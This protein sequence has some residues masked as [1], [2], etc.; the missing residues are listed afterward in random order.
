CVRRTLAHAPI[1]AALLQACRT[2]VTTMPMDLIQQLDALETA[3]RQAGL[4]PDQLQRL[5]KGV[6]GELDTS[7]PADGP[8]AERLL[9]PVLGDVLLGVSPDLA[10]GA[11]PA[12]PSGK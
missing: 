10:A 7:R 2:L 5:F 1:R 3:A 8:P 4:T 12:A 11:T 9:R 6:Y